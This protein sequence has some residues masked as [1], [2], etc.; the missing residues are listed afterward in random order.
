MEF[1]LILLLDVRIVES[2]HAIVVSGITIVVQARDWNGCH[3]RSL[4]TL[5]QMQAVKA[6]RWRG[7]QEVT[8]GGHSARKR[9][10]NYLIKIYKLKLMLGIKFNYGWQADNHK[11][12]WLILQTPRLNQSNRTWKQGSDFLV[13]MYRPGVHACV[14]IDENRTNTL[15]IGVSYIIKYTSIVRHQNGR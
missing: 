7:A 4:S 6:G 8:G 9:N 3:K 1:S 12:V 5:F 15:A 10:E 11:R 14:K 2:I 13:A